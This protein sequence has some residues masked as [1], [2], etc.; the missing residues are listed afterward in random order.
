MKRLFPG[1]IVVALMA[2]AFIGYTT[3]LMA[4]TKVLK[5]QATRPASLTH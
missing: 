4:Q 5:I 1:L 2:S 3:A